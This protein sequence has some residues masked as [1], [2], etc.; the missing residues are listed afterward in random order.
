MATD[1]SPVGCTGKVIVATRGEAG[2][3]EVLLQ[4]KGGTEAY[5]A[6]SE[7]P[8]ARGTAVLVF[9]ARGGREVDVMEFESAADGEDG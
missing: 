2:P 6:W 8:L 7:E 1:Q 4:I 9:N 3:G 5:M